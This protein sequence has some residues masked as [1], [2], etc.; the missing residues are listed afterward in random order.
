MSNT[1]FS[2]L[3]TYLGRY[4][5]PG[6]SALAQL[7][8]QN[9]KQVQLELDARGINVALQTTT[10]QTPATLVETTLFTYTIVAGALSA[11]GNYLF[12]LN[13]FGSKPNTDMVDLKLYLGGVLVA[14]TTL[15]STGIWTLTDQIVIGSLNW[16][17]ASGGSGA[18]DVTADQIL[19]L[20][21]TNHV[22]TL[23]DLVLKCASFELLAPLG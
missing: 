13:F 15:T 11:T 22:A 4:L 6:A 14:T 19:K 3:G 12:R 8:E 7:L 2:R 21:G 1:I 23:G 16:V 18:I 20:T 10:K 17:S 9:L 5:D